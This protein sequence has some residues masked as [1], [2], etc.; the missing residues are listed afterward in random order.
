MNFS[1]AKYLTANKIK[2]PAQEWKFNKT[3]NINGLAQILYYEL[4]FFRSHSGI[5][6]IIS[7]PNENRTSRGFFIVSN[8]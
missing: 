8:N 5:L 7:K 6:K 2:H 1:I 4:K 3:K